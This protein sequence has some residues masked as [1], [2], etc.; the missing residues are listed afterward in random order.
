MGIKSNFET[1]VTGDRAGVVDGTKRSGDRTEG[2]QAR[3]LGKGD[4]DS[5]LI[6]SF[7]RENTFFYFLFVVDGCIV[8]R[9]IFI[10]PLLLLFL[11]LGRTTRRAKV[12]ERV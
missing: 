10:F 2:A 6:Y 9:L 12:G 11:F 5:R 7:L 8:L 1:G 3:A 4:G